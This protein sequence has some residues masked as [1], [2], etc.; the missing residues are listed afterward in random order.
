[1]AQ[2]YVTAGFNSLLDTLQVILGMSANHLT[3]AT[4]Q[5]K[6]DQTVTK[7][8]HKN[9]NNGYEKLMC[10]NNLNLMKL[11]PGLDTSMLSRIGP[12]L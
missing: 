8:Q 4:T 9:L 7:L 6:P 1:M 10:T 3:G 11:K 5:F 2:K 12:I